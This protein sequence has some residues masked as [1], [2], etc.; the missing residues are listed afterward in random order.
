MR[1]R[2]YNVSEE[3]PRVD[4]MDIRILLYENLQFDTVIMWPELTSENTMRSRLLPS[5]VNLTTLAASLPLV[6]LAGLELPVTGSTMTTEGSETPE[7]RYD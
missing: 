2:D 5:G 4:D 3:S 6:E 7:S 1:D